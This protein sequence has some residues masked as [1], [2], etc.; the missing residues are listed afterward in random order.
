MARASLAR[1]RPLGRAIKKRP[2][3]QERPY[4]LRMQSRQIFVPAHTG[5]RIPDQRHITKQRSEDV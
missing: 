3:V 1:L 4:K 5:N 2:A